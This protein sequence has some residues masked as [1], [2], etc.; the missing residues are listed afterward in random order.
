MGEWGPL[1]EEFFLGEI[2]LEA[3]YTRWPFSAMAIQPDLCDATK[4]ARYI[5]AHG[6]HLRPPV[7][8][9]RECYVVD[10]FERLDEI[11]IAAT[12][13]GLAECITEEE[14]EEI[15]VAYEDSELDDAWWI[16]WRCD[17]HVHVVIAVLRQLHTEGRLP[18]K[19]YW[20][21]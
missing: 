15:R 16:A 1:V 21:A 18:P 17:Q 7:S 14:V 4:R 11:S 3:F 19:D 6:Y 10:S 9:E 2:N 12:R 8:G 13:R 20:G 5:E